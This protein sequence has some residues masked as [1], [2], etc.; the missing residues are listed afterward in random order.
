M[1][2][3][4]TAL[5][6]SVYAHATVTILPED[7]AYITYRYVLNLVGGNGLVY[8]PGERVFG[9][10]TPLYALWLSALKLAFPAF[11]VPDLAVRSNVVFHVAA[12]AALAAL[13]HAYARSR[14]LG[15]ATAA[16]VLAHPGI[17]ILSLDGMETMLF[18]GAL[19]WS[20]WGLA[21]DR[22]RLAAVLAGLSIL[23]R[24]EGV[25]AAAVVGLYCLVYRRRAI[26]TVAA[27]LALPV[28]VWSVFAILYYGTPVPHSIVA[29]RHLYRHP[30]GHALRLVI[31]AIDRWTTNRR[32]WSFTELRLILVGNLL[33]LA[34]LGFYVLRTRNMNAWWV[35]PVLF[36]ALVAFYSLA[37]PQ[38]FSWY[39]GSIWLLWLLTMV[40]GWSEL[41]RRVG[42]ERGAAVAGSVVLLLLVAVSVDAYRPLLA[43]GR[44]PD[45]YVAD[46]Y[47]H[48]VVEYREAA[49]W[50]NRTAPRQARVLAPEIG[51][52]GY[53]AEARILDS[54]GLVSPEAL[55]FLPVA[56]AGGVGAI[57]VGLVR[58]SAPEYIVTLKVFAGHELL[59]DPWFES[60]HEVVTRVPLRVPVWGSDE[61]L[62]FRRR[63]APR[64]GPARGPRTPSGARRRACPPARRPGC[65][66]SRR[67]RCAGRSRRRS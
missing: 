26:V 44:V 42:G 14:R 38:M 21:T 7:D 60:Q 53:F 43:R 33:Q 45:T 32:L 17:L 63:T 46:E 25:L 67:G 11:D 5:A 23:I 41:G 3:V 6:L 54:A 24:P 59:G 10:T 39:F 47:R 1:G 55:P 61:V 35:P 50:L 19:L 66:C 49:E 2:A 4:L 28:L 29:K 13:V 22:L 62:V 31:D 34:A 52:L 56:G 51:A 27:L 57:P 36:G 16:L 12:A 8:N 9:A 30:R 40:V 37:N 18:G 20:V 58:A 65:P 48:R 15:L 64:A